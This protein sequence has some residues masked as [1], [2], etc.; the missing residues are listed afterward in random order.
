MLADQWGTE[1]ECSKGMCWLTN[2]EQKSSDHSMAAIGG[3]QNPSKSRRGPGVRKRR[4]R[5]A[6]VASGRLAMNYTSSPSSAKTYAFNLDSQKVA[7]G[8][9]VQNVYLRPRRPYTSPPASLAKRSASG[10]AGKR[11]ASDLVGKTYAPG[12]VAW[13]KSPPPA[14]SANNSASG[15]VGQKVP[16]QTK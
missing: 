15:L 16:S 4:A 7:T 9:V 12:L 1:K 11:Y 2:G 14:S 3:A 6:F 8:L 5:G 10:L 13:P